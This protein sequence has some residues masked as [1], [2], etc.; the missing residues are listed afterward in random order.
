M[1]LWLNN[2]T[3]LLASLKNE[4]TVDDTWMVRGDDVG[5]TSLVDSNYTGLNLEAWKWLTS[6]DS[7]TTRVRPA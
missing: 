3:E 1:I 2:S 6:Y 7:W 5:K 4:S